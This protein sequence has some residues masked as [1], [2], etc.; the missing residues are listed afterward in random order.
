MKKQTHSFLAFCLSALVLFSTACKKDKDED[1]Q[2]KTKSELLVG[3]WMLTSDAYNP[4]YDFTGSGTLVTE[5]Y[6][7]Y[8]SC[9]KD[10]VVTFKTGGTGEF[11]EGATKCDPNANQ[12][13][14]F[15]WALTNNDNTLVI[16]GQQF[17]LVQVDN[18]TLKVSSA[19]TESGVNYTN[20]LTFTRK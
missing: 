19:F 18:S 12:T 7:F 1:E 6:P 5:G 13:E 2:Q 20:T 4:G 9:E 3:N 11:S 8:E 16:Q 10:D 17:N 14:P 15:T